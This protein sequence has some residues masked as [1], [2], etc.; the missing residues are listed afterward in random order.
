MD[1]DWRGWKSGKYDNRYHGVKRHSGKRHYKSRSGKN[2]ALGIILGV[3]I[4]IAGLYLYEN[5]KVPF[6]N[7]TSNLKTS[8][9]TTS[10][11]PTSSQENNNTTSV[12]QPNSSIQQ[13]ASN[14]Q[15]LAQQEEATS[16]SAQLQ[17]RQNAV[18]LGQE[19][20]QRQAAEQAQLKT[21]TQSY[22]E[23]LGVTP[24]P[25]VTTSTTQGT[26][27]QTNPN[28]I[29]IS[30]L[31]TLRQFMLNNLNNYRSQ[32]GLSPLA[33]DNEQPTQNWAEQLLSEKCIHHVSDT[34]V[35]PQGRYFEA[36]L[37]GFAISENVAGGG[38]DS[39]DPTQFISDMDN[40][41]MNDDSASNWGHRDNIL[42]PSNRYVSIGI[43]YNSTDMVF[44]QDFEAPLQGGEYMPPSDYT[45]TPDQKSC[46]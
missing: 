40:Q 19:E 4:T 6:S 2:I 46:W 16:N 24:A 17:A 11:L 35:T 27:P 3:G 45:S 29:Q 5:Y 34:G 18:L 23:K 42:N 36:G 21:A 9:N 25:Q 8:S 32:A 1:D 33:L 22:D 12:V 20:Q 43:A 44:V 10:E 14:I 37:S 31:D 41:M 28:Q 13:N 39:G 15:T 26:T 30:D 7:P 38:T